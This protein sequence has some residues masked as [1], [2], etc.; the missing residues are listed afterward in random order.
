MKGQTVG[1]GINSKLML[2][3]MESNDV[4]AAFLYTGLQ[5]YYQ[6][7]NLTNPGESEYYIGLDLA[8]PKKF[9]NFD[10]SEYR[11]AQLSLLLRGIFYVAGDEE[12]KV[13]L[14]QN[15]QI[16]LPVTYLSL[17]KAS[18]STTNPNFRSVALGF[19]MQY[20]VGL[21]FRINDK[22]AILPNI[23]LGIGLLSIKQAI[24]E[25]FNGYAQIN[26]QIKAVYTLSE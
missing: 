7:P 19:G 16:E 22:L 5:A 24:T 6:S 9:T 8:L 2:M 11:F 12:S 23:N 25:E 26:F 4:S 3:E 15:Y 1:G 13:S 17:I 21:R 18:G 14:N 10:L 20:G